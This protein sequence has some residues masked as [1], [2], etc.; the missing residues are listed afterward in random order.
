MVFNKI[1]NGVRLTPDEIKGYI[2]KFTSDELPKIEDKEESGQ[3]HGKSPESQM[4]IMVAVPNIQYLASEFKAN[5]H[6]VVKLTDSK[7][8]ENLVRFVFVACL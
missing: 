2:D 3:N 7:D 5:A 1:K 4:E 8:M 6:N